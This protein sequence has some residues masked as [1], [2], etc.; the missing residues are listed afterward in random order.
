M[1]SQ[2]PGT[3]TIGSGRNF[4]VTMTE[5]CSVDESKGTQSQGLRPSPLPLPHLRSEGRLPNIK[6]IKLD[7][8]VPASHTCCGAHNL[9]LFA[10][11]TSRLWRK[12]ASNVITE[13]TLN[14]HK[15][16]NASRRKSPHFTCTID[17]RPHEAHVSREKQQ[18][19]GKLFA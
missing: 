4:A 14:M 9:R 19:V 16:Q 8:N 15:Q 3:G 12:S 7:P 2:A 17:A 10:P 6:K 5:R 18:T 1:I 11:N 13:S